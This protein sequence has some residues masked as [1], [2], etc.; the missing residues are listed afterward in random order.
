VVDVGPA[1][2]DILR[3]LENESGIGHANDRL[4][5][6]SQALDY[7]PDSELCDEAE[8]VAEHAQ[9]RERQLLSEAERVLAVLWICLARDRGPT[10]PTR[11]PLQGALARPITNR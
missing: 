2:T 10:H 4:D 9:E 11:P 1:G 7:S 6:A 3:Y 8:V 5:G